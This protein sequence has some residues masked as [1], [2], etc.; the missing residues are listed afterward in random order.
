MQA[1]VGKKRDRAATSWGVL[2][3]YMLQLNIFFQ[4]T[5]D[6]LYSCFDWMIIEC[7]RLTAENS[8]NVGVIEQLIIAVS[9]LRA[10][11]GSAGIANPLGAVEKTIFWDKI[12]TSH[13]VLGMHYT[14][15]RVEACCMVIK[16][17]LGIT[18][19][20]N[21]VLHAVPL[22]GFAYKGKYPFY[23]V[24]KGGWP[25]CYTEIENPNVKIPLQEEALTDEQ[26]AP[27]A[28]VHFKTENWD[29]V[30]SVIDDKASNLVDYKSIV[31]KSA[32]P[33]KGEY[34]FFSAV[35]EEGWF[36]YRAL[37]QSSVATFCGAINTLQCGSKTADLVLNE[38]VRAK[39]LSAGFPDI[40]GCF[41]PTYVLQHYGYFPPDESALP[42]VFRFN[43]FVTGDVSLPSSRAS[44]APATP[45]KVLSRSST[46]DENEQT[47]C[48]GVPP[49]DPQMGGSNPVNRST[50]KENIAPSG[51]EKKGKKRPLSLID[52]QADATDDDDDEV[53]SRH[54]P[55]P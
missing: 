10:D 54:T 43:P 44:S 29:R 30:L 24:G 17:V 21:E 45:D 42:I 14:S 41:E 19:K 20:P 34:C 1:A 25:I 26:L 49:R 13:T 23:D 16:S 9:K 50:D 5:S 36:G 27:F 7:T 32:N 51:T 15:L 38:K 35:T 11:K 4:D 55:T 6:D 22:C 33:E 46:F 52:D 47:K 8:S 40:A 3:Y 12:R 2:L 28:C 48:A 18:I 31:I 37:A 53:R 39:N